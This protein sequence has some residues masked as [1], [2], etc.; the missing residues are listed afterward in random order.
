MTGVVYKPLLGMPYVM[1]EQNRELQEAIMDWPRCVLQ[2]ALLFLVKNSIPTEPIWT[3]FIASAAE[4]TLRRGIAPTNPRP[5]TLLPEDVP[6]EEE[7]NTKCWEHG[8]IL[9]NFGVPP[10]EPFRGPYVT[11]HQVTATPGRVACV[12]IVAHSHLPCMGL[13][14]TAFAEPQPP[15]P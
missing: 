9:A 3:A 5:G 7:L 1:E 11:H 14:N 6:T 2:V 13:A 12:R 15:R 10:R 4:L 8:G